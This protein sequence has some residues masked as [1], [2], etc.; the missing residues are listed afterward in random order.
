MAKRY[1]EE[2]YFPDNITVPAGI[3]DIIGITANLMILNSLEC[4]FT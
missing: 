3:K 4:L 1:G 2:H